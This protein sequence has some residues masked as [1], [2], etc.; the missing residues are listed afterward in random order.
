M[1]I[2]LSRAGILIYSK[3]IIQSEMASIQTPQTAEAE[4]ERWASMLFI[5]TPWAKTELSK[6]TLAVAIVANLAV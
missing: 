5:A 3:S 2:P 4:T 1:L 6:F